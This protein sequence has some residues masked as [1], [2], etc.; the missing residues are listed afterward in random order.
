[1]KRT[2]TEEDAVR[3]AE[4]AGL[5]KALAEYRDDVLGAAKSAMDARNAFTATEDA[6]V[7]PCPAMRVRGAA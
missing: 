2:L 4:A 6:A 1:L 7:E 5:Q 3:I